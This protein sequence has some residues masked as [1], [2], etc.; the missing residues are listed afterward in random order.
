MNPKNIIIGI[1]VVLVLII[2]IQNTQVVILRLL[3]WKVRM[4]QI[5]LV[6]LTFILGFVIGYFS[7]TVKNK[8]KLKNTTVKE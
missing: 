5:V 3:F 1:I 2:L 8:N 4:S 6:P 7:R